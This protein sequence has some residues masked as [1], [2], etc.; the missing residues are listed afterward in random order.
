MGT[1]F[2]QPKI[3]PVLAKIKKKGKSSESEG[4]FN[5][6]TFVL[7]GEL[8]SMSRDEAKEKIRDLNGDISESVSKKTDYVIVGREP[9]SKYQR[10][11][12]LGVKI[13]NE[14]KFLNLLK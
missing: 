1:G 3:I 14:D 13:L 2:A 5:G 12:K 9:G 8:E 11:Q 6:L 10:A 7:T 4:K